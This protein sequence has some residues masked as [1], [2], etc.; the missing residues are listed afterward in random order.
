MREAVRD[1]DCCSEIA[2]TLMK[3]IEEISNAQE[4]E[5]TAFR[6][7]LD[8]RGPTP[9]NIEAECVQLRS[10]VSGLEDELAALTRRFVA[11]DHTWDEEKAALEAARA[12][13]CSRADGLVLELVQARSYIH[14]TFEGLVIPEGI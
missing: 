14:S 9:P 12:Q 10:Q 3:D 13:A 8:R 2:D 5:L 6:V 7:K 1:R 11:L 4:S